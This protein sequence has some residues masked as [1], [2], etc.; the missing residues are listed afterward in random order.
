M[1]LKIAYLMCKEWVEE[2]WWDLVDV[3]DRLTER[4]EED[5]SGNR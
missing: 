1:D 3:W 4:K 2:R 5:D